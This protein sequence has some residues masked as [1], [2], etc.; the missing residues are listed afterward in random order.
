MTNY[1]DEQWYDK[2]RQITAPIGETFNLLEPTAEARNIKRQEFEESGFTAVV[3]LFPEADVLGPLEL[4]Y[5]QLAELRRDIETQ[6]L[7]TLVRES[8][9]AYIDDVRLNIDLVRAGCQQD[10][11]NYE[12][13]NDQLYGKPD[14][15]LYRD[16]CDW[17]IHDAR[18]TLERSEDPALISSG[19]EV[20][21]R[22][23]QAG[24]D[25]HDLIPNAEVFNRVRESHLKPG[26]FFDKLFGADGLPSEPY[27]AQPEGDIICQNVLDNIGADYEIVDS[28]N[29]IWSV[30][31]DPMEL[32][33]PTGYRLA[34]DEFIGIVAHEIGSHI[35]ESVNGAKQPLRLFEMGIPGYVLGNEGRAL[36]REQIVYTDVATALAQPAW[37]YCMM[38]HLAISLALGYHEDRRYQ[39][40]EIYDILYRLYYFWRLRRY[41][42]DTNNETFARE[43]AWLL[44]VRL[45]KG[46]DGAGGCYQKDIV[47][48]E[49]NV[50]TWRLAAQDPE[51]VL[52]GDQGKFNLLDVNQRNLFK[53]L[54]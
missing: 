29:H 41:P 11:Q 32:R 17:I 15:A 27:I 21:K 36:L 48:L 26:G 33:R 20:L 49:G 43:E 38:Q 3:T 2:L 39:L 23:P 31:R 50:K 40:P 19:N 28:Q 1:L 9:L 54:S 37:E 5:E 10:S 22:I 25:Y 7:N 16:V 52:L 51:I 45:L 13:L 24:G 4:P 42:L 46:T 18:A 53:A 34:R 44:A 6:E 14:Q 30:S 8:Y 47:Y 12:R 35:Y